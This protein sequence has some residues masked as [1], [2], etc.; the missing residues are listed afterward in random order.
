M[1]KEVLYHNIGTK[2]PPNSLF[3]LKLALEFKGLFN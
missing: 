1:T 2:W 3:G